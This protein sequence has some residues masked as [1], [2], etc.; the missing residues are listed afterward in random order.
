MDTETATTLKGLYAAGD[1]A[2]VPV[3]YLSGAFVYGE[4]AG[5]SAAKYAVH[6]DTREID[7]DLIQ[8]Q[9]DKI[10]TQLDRSDGIKPNEFELRLRNMITEYLA[11]P[12]NAEKL[13]NALNLIKEFRKDI[14]NLKVEDLHELGKAVEARFILDCAE[15]TARS[16]LKRQETRWGKSDFRSDFLERDDKNWLKFVD[17]KMDQKTGEMNIFTSPVKRRKGKGQK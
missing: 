16:A 15:M 14:E 9:A 12:R 1:V 7:Q 6:T 17:L 13:E 5:Q 11:P 2:C 8:K 4:I 3:Q 10:F